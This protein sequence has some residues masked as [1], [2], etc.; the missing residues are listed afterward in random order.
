MSV[1][2]T[3]GEPRDPQEPGAGTAFVIN[4]SGARQEFASGMVRDTAEGK[5]DFTSVLFGPM[6]KRWAVHL[7]KGRQK[8][9]D[10]EPG[11]PNWTLAEG[12]EEY[13]RA[14]QSLL[15]HTFAYLDGEQDEDHA[16]AMFFN[17]NLME[18]VKDKAG[19][20]GDWQLVGDK[21]GEPTLI[22]PHPDLLKCDYP[23]RVYE[24]RPLRAK[25][26]RWW[27]RGT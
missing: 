18:Y 11:I 2:N 27:N 9:P 5:T 24:Y 22:V 19:R 23:G 1:D 21:R 12:R 13:E 6:L 7:T 26:Q 17:V 20:V 4:D 16:A 8:Y 25:R 3:G 14:K 15:R 10:P